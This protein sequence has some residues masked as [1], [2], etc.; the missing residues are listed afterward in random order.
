MRQG[1]KSSLR[2]FRKRGNHLLIQRW[3]FSSRGKKPSLVIDESRVFS[4]C[5]CACKRLMSTLVLGHWGYIVS[6][7]HLPRVLR[8]T[9]LTAGIDKTTYRDNDTSE[10]LTMTLE[11][12][13]PTPVWAK[14]ALKRKIPLIPSFLS[15]RLVTFHTR[16]SLVPGRLGLHTLL[17][18]ASLGAVKG[19]A[20][21]LFFQ[22]LGCD[23]CL[24]CALLSQC[25]CVF[26]KGLQMKPSLTFLAGQ[27]VRSAAMTPF[28]LP[29]S[30]SSVFLWRGMWPLWR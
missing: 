20:A 6:G 22:L 4:W 9:C 25:G 19:R 11:A 28:F 3:T 1:S 14:G 5:V 23:S 21:G 2:M 18:K 16:P 10:Y 7:V 29:L 12:F 26:A 24:Y 8:S 17:W 27:R 13:R 15:G 30:S